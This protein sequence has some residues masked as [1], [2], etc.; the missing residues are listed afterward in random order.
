[1]HPTRER[2]TTREWI[3]AAL[4]L[5]LLLL[6]ALAIG[7]VVS[8][9]RFRT[10][11]LP[12]FRATFDVGIWSLFVTGLLW[13]VAMGI[14]F[15]ILGLLAYGLATR[16]WH[17]RRGEWHRLVVRKGVRA[18]RSATP[19][20]GGQSGGAETAPM[21]ETAVRVLAGVN[22]AVLTGVIT[23]IV[24]TAVERLLTGSLWVLIPLG[25]V[26][27][28]GLY[29]LL[30]EWGP[31]KVGPRAHAGIWV[32]VALIAALLT[33]L[34]LGLLILIGTAISTA[35]RSVA[36][37]E[38]PRTPVALLRSPLPWTLVAGYALVGVAYYAVPPVPFGRDLLST[39]SGQ[40]LAG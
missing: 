4:D 16:K 34:P 21:G 26:V 6:V 10:A 31:L 29:W 12:A 3:A 19:G 9:V 8:W 18:A 1:V 7:A 36:R 5:I 39:T 15:S 24:V 17:D 30:T 27:F 32:V 28:L 11:Q 2:R 35:G 23:A 13:L 33:T 38:L 14:A 25:L 22:L 40:R 37:G 20:S